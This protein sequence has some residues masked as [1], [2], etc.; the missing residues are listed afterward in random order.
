MDPGNRLVASELERRWNE[1]LIQVSRQQAEIDELDA[2]HEALVTP[3]QRETLLALGADLRRVWDHAAAGNESRKRILRTVS[4]RAC[5]LFNFP[6][7]LDAS[8][9]GRFAGGCVA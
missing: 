2:R 6:D 5:E 8:R 9:L 1:G 4:L 7:E 3:H